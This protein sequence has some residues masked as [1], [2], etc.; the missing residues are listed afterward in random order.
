M[1]LLFVMLTSLWMEFLEPKTEL[2]CFFSLI[3]GTKFVVNS[4]EDD[5]LEA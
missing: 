1:L 4:I 2:L 5:V 3:E